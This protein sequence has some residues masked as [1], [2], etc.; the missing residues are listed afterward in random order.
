MRPDRMIAALTLAIG[1]V[2]PNA[3]FAVPYA[4]LSSTETQNGRVGEGRHPFN[5]C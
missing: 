1:A 4:Q 5:A 3:S 2:F